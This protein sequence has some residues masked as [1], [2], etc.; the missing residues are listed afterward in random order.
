MNT[1][2]IKDPDTGDVTKVL[3]DKYGSTFAIQTEKGFLLVDKKA[4]TNEE[5]KLLYNNIQEK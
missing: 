1:Q 4:L 2:L 3:R 5:V